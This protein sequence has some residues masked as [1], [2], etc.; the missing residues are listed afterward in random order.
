MERMGIEDSLKYLVDSI[1]EIRKEIADMNSQINFKTYTLKDIAIMLN[2]HEQSLR[3]K[4]WKMPNFGKADIGNQPRRWF[5]KTVYDW[6]LIPEN[7][8]QSQWETM[9]SRERCEAIGIKREKTVVYKT[10]TRNTAKAG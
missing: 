8:R 3:N 7:E 4:P 10:K 9:T 6:Y 1:S 2:C 5:H